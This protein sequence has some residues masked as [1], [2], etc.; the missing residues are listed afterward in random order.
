M[1]RLDQA[2]FLRS[3]FGRHD[4]APGGYVLG[5]EALAERPDRGSYPR[6]A[7]RL[8]GAVPLVSKPIERLLQFA[9]IPE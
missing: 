6:F 2:A 8:D 1:D 9:E 4:A 5:H 7:T 3:R